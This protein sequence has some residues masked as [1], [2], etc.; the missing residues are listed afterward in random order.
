MTIGSG[1]G[2]A[3]AIIPDELSRPQAL[4]H[5]FPDL[6]PWRQRSCCR[7]Y[8]RHSRELGIR[9]LDVW[10]AVVAAH[11]QGRAAGD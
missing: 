6:L 10:S 7:L 3:T 5:A 8:R 11:A 4:E 9:V 2:I 1:Q